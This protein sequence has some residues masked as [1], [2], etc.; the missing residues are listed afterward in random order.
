[1]YDHFLVK[2][3][4]KLEDM[5]PIRGVLE[6]RHPKAHRYW[7]VSGQLISQIEEA[8][9][10]LTCQSL[11]QGG[12]VFRGNAAVGLSAATFFWNRASMEPDF[13]A[14]ENRFDSAAERFWRLV[15][16]GL[17]ITTI[18]RVGNRYGYLFPTAAAEEL[19]RGM[20]LWEA[21]E[22]L[23]P[24]G[25]P[26]SEGVALRFKMAER[27]VRVRLEVDAGSTTVAGKEKEGVLLDI[28]FSMVEVS[29]AD[30][31][32]GRFIRENQELVRTHLYRLLR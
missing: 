11:E 26:S 27:P 29:A 18:T 17:G 30:L 19:V 8:L 21:N 7:D 32:L 13:A 15:Q 10:G 9:P 23:S 3:P 14:L 28:D 31:D 22:R 1:M 25:V 12:F 5:V 4:G 24:F 20:R 6:L 2:A 16:S